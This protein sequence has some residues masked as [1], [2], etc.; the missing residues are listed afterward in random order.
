MEC[1]L[2]RVCGILVA[3]SVLAGVVSAQTSAPARPNVVLIVTDDVGYGD[4]G[5]YGAPD[6]HT[7]NIDRLAAEGAKL[8]DFY[9]SPQCTPT[10]ASLISGRYQQRFRME[11][12]IVAPATNPEPEI[13]LPATGRSLPQL[14]KNRGYTTGLLGKWH[15]GWRPQYRPTAH[16][17]DYFFGFLS[18]FTDYYQHTDGNG[19]ADL[20]EN[21]TPVH[22]DGYMTDLLTER[23]VKFIDDNRARPFFLEVAYN[24]AHWPFQLPDHPSTAPGNARFVQP[25][26]DEPS[27]RLD[28]IK[29]LERADQGIGQIVAVL[30]RLNLASNT[31]II[32][33]NDNGGEWLSRNAPLFHYKDSLWEGGIRVPA[34]F[35]WPGHIPAGTV[36]SQ[37]GITM[38][39]TATI[40]GVA[41]ATVPQD[42]AL[43]GTNLMPILEGKAPS[44]QRTLF[45]RI[46]TNQKTQRAVRQG[47]WKLLVDGG[48][49]FL[50]NLTQ[51]IGERNNLVSVHPEIVRIMRPLLN[52]W[53]QDVDAEAMRT[54][55]PTLNTAGGNPDAGGRGGRGAGARG[56]GPGGGVRA[57]GGAAQAP[58]D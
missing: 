36:S 35:R 9:A 24:A 55:A 21:N 31:L 47:E 27:T 46:L 8:T 26:D 51:D 33:T 22:V 25:T 48:R 1:L 56:N 4:F 28:Y 52:T 23:A 2:R 54:L 40:L 6:I 20:Y 7:P 53:E 45:W 43:E 49:L 16:G 42:A 41:G 50:F 19:H 14:L 34:I 11:R 37:V 17:F 10:R 38:D 30:Q 5:A 39:L 15:L 29:V 44:L 13:G 57:G 32:F 58:S 3:W 18:G 12:A